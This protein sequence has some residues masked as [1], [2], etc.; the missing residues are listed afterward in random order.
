MLRQES[1]EGLG[2]QIYCSLTDEEIGEHIGI[3]RET[4][5]R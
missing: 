2:A 4:V 1:H 3:S 5:T